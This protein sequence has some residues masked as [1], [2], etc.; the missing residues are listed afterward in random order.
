MKLTSVVTLIFLITATSGCVTLREP[1]ITK[2]DDIRN[3]RFVV[4]PQ[5]ASLS[6]ESGAVYGNQ[7]GIYGSSSAK[8]INP[9]D[10]IEGILLKRGLISIE[11]VV[12]ED[13]DKTLLV[14]Y[15][16]SGRRDVAGGP[17]RLYIRGNHCHGV[18]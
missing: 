14:R 13:E 1:E 12:P 10:L 11:N 6:S 2:R 7:Y 17:T 8:S 9:G 3:Y 4:V 5:T 15:G 18:C 16:E